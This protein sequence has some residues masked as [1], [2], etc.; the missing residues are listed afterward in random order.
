MLPSR[1]MRL[2]VAAVKGQ[3]KGRTPAEA[4]RRA[5]LD[6]M[7]DRAVPGAADPSVWAPFMVIGR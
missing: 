7:D 4:L 6:L 1:S 3:A 5:M 2:T